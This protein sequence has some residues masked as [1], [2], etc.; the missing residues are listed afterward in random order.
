MVQTLTD[1]YM[2]AQFNPGLVY[3]GSVVGKVAMRHV[4]LRDLRTFFIK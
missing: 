2:K 1:L 4:S 3:V